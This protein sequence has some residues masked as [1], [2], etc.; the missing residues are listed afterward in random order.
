M[1][2]HSYKKRYL[3]D[4]V[5]SDIYSR[6]MRFIAGPRQVGKTTIAKNKL[7]FGHSEQFY[8]NWDRKEVRDRYRKET[9]FLTTDLLKW[10][11]RKNTWVC[12]D[13]IHKMPKWKNL[14]KGFFDTYE[15]KINFII[16][17]SARLDLFRKAGDSLAGRYFLFKL[18]PLILPEVLGRKISNILPENTAEVYIE[19]S[20]AGKKYEQDALENIMRFSGFP[21]PLLSGNVIFSRKWHDNYL[22]RI[23]KEDIRD[24]SAIHQLEKILDLL[25][26]LPAKIGSPLSI[27]SL[28]EDLEINFNT[29]KNYLNYLILTYV[30]FE[31]FPYQKQINRLVK[32]EKKVYCYDFA[33]INDEAKRFENL[34]ALELK[35]RVDLWND[36]LPDKYELRF[37]RTR[38]GNETDFLIL[39]NLQPFFL[40]EV[41][42]SDNNIAKH[43]YLHAKYLGDIPF[44]QV[45]KQTGILKTV[46]HGFYLV[47]A[48]RFF[49]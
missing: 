33:I 25:Y 26:L 3:E 31:I 47:S 42:L 32:K 27:N 1:T 8:Y 13:E 39:K 10:P 49:S 40:C 36:L 29:V 5:F 21:E 6:Q 9:N 11:L 4:I 12:F 14:L 23:V 15:D 38:E 28:T 48:S 22:E 44:V 20:I 41:K 35:S 18:N 19:K 43:H 34:V 37:V 2:R 46:Q 16:T 24:I 7:A 45:I 17:G 30:L